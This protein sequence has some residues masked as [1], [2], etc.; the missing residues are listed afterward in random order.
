MIRSI[1]LKFGRAEGLEPETISAMPIT[2]FVG[3]NNSGKSKILSEIYQF[4]TSG[5][6]DER[7][8]II[9][10]VE[11]SSFTDELIDE[12]I[13]SISLQPIPEEVLNPGDIVIISPSNREIA[14]I[15]QLK[16]I[17]KTPNSESL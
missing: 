10:F 16:Q 7:N 14:N 6:V 17:L 2:L 1:K 3:P 12:K 9:D 11:L 4:C 8:V 5:I 15:T 13:E